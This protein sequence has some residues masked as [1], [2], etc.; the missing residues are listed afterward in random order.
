MLCDADKLL[1]TNKRATAY[2][3]IIINETTILIKRNLL[4]GVERVRGTLVRGVEEVWSRG[5]EKVRGNSIFSVLF[6][7]ISNR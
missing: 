5:V 1:I 4:M 3:Y 6:S 7:D 2:P